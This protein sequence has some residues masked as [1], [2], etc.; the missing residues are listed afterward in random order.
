MISPCV[1]LCTVDTER[2]ACVGCGRTLTEI[3][4]WTRISDAER[5]AIMDALPARLAAWQ[6]EWQA[7][8]RAEGARA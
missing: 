3:G 2:R 6:R 1:R 5:L 7:A 8:H 4:S